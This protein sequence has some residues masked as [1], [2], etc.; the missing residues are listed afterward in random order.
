VANDEAGA[1]ADAEASVVELSDRPPCM[2]CGNP[3]T[4]PET[5]SMEL[6]HGSGRT[7]TFHGVPGFLCTECGTPARPAWVV[8]DL[9]EAMDAAVASGFEGNVLDYVPRQKDA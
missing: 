1:G 2:I 8:F 3:Q 5:A 9:F 6:Q 4:Q 7:F